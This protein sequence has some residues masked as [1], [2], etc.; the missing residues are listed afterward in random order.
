MTA[1]AAPSDPYYSSQWALPRVRAPGAWALSTGSLSTKLCVVD[2][3]VDASHPDLAANVAGPG[4]NAVSGAAGAPDLNEHGT[5]VAGIAGAVGDNAVGVAGVSW[6]V[7]LLPCKFMDAAGT[8]SMADGIK[9]WYVGRRA[10][11]VGR[12]GRV[13]VCVGGCTQGTVTAMPTPTI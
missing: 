6:A 12:A 7:T 10:G 5:H 1:S 2:T 8:G 4:Y 11:W 9:C 3:G 13:G